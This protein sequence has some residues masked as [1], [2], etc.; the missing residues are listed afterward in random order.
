MCSRGIIMNNF[1]TGRR[2]ALS[3]VIH[4]VKCRNEGYPFILDGICTE[5]F[6]KNIVCRNGIELC[7]L[8]IAAGNSGKVVLPDG[9]H[10]LHCG[11]VC[12]IPANVPFSVGTS[13][14][15]AALH[16]ITF[17]CS[18]DV[19][20]D[21][22]YDRYFFSEAQ[23]PDI[24]T[25]LSVK[26]AETAADP[27]ADPDTISVQLYHLLLAVRRAV[28]LQDEEKY[29]SGDLLRESLKFMDKYYAQDISLERLAVISGVSLQHF[30]RVFKARIGMRPMEYLAKRRTAEAKELLASTDMKIGEIAQAVGFEDANYFGITFRKYEGATPTEYRRLFGK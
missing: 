14:G 4:P 18:A 5:Y 22:G 24:M 2:G 16:Y 3:K 25:A 15:A 23:K 6:P 10:E 12:F 11:S 20:A 30:C 8:Y 7:S 13:D 26:L 28:F 29:C 19:A 21:L 9:E 17:S 27:L 1:G